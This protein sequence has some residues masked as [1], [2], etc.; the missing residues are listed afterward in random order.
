M[1]EASILNCWG[2]FKVSEVLFICIDKKEVSIWT[3]ESRK[4]SYFKFGLTLL[5]VV[6]KF[7]ERATWQEVKSKCS[8]CN[9]CSVLKRSE[10]WGLHVEP[11]EFV[12]SLSDGTVEV[13]KWPIKLPFLIKPT[14][15]RAEFTYTPMHTSLLPQRLG[16]AFWS[17]EK[18]L[19]V[20]KSKTSAQVRLK[21]YIQ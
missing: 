9:L 11:S 7:T 20:K 19:L 5:W 18:P 16:F 21:D 3:Q 1:V 12:K 13:P 14:K 4:V 8:T 17:I 10:W 15:S 2:I 6:Y